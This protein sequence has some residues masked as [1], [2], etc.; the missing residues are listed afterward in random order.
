MIKGII[1]ERCLRTS[2]MHMWQF[3]NGWVTQFT[4]DTLPFVVIS[5]VCDISCIIRYIGPKMFPIA[6][7]HSSINHARLYLSVSVS[8]LYCFHMPVK[9]RA[10]ACI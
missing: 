10:Y 7:R 6:E 2:S 4:N 1:N 5:F 8:S 3:K 9:N